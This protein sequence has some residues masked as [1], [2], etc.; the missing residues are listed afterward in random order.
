LRSYEVTEAEVA[1]ILPGMDVG[2]F[3]GL[4]T[5]PDQIGKVVAGVERAVAASFAEDRRRNLVI[6]VQRVTQA[7]VKR[8]GRLC[9][10]IFKVLRGDLHWSWQR[11][12]DHLPAYLRQALD[13]Q[14]W[15]PEARQRAMWAPSKVG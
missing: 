13:G 12:V 2:V 14:D 6:Q 3:A 1:A 9:V 4:L 11:A 5:E 10:E 15:E 8:R 7:E